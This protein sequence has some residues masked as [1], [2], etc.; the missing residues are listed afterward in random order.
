LLGGGT[1][2][3]SSKVDDNIA[4]IELRFGEAEPLLDVLLTTWPSAASAGDDLD[5]EA[6]V[7][8]RT[9]FTAGRGPSALQKQ[10]L[11][12]SATLWS[13]RLEVNGFHF[14]SSA[15]GEGMSGIKVI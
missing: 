14:S 4:G 15:L 8:F 5:A 12:N 10:W 6:V 1:G 13:F 2:E 7:L 9:H 11:R 3:G